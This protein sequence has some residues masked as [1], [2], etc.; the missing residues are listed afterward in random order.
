MTGVLAASLPVTARAMSGHGTG[1]FS[2]GGSH[3]SNHQGFSH[4]FGS[5]QNFRGHPFGA[6]NHYFHNRRYFF[7]GFDFAAFGFPYWWYPDYP[8]GYASYD[9]SPV[10]DYRYWYGLSA[11]V[12]AE[13]AQRGYYHGPIDG[14]IGSESREAIRSFQQAK[15]LPVT[16]LIDPR[17]LR[18]LKLPAVPRVAASEHGSALDFG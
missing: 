1:G 14:V 15:G 7:F 3:S 4:Q 8:Y 11:A 18:A 17:L 2:G 12:Q 10:Y 9:Y 5:R 16:G 13:L 6:H